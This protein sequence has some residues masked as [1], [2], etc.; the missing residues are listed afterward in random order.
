M[1]VEDRG[2]ITESIGILVPVDSFV[3]YFTFRSDFIRLMEAV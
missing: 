2:R 1:L 3:Q